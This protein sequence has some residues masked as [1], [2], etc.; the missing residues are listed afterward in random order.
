[1]TNGYEFDK[2][3]I[4]EIRIVGHLD[5]SW[6]DWFCGFKITSTGDGTLLSGLVPDQSAL[7]GL[8]A[9]LGEMGVTLLSIEPSGTTPGG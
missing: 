5:P 8:L 3:A 4:Y 9:K 1:M 7:Y 6:S 2:A